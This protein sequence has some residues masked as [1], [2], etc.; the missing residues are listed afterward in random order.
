MRRFVR[1]A[2]H[3]HHDDEFS[4]YGKGLLVADRPATYESQRI[5]ELPPWVGPTA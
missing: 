2:L 4:V 1:G 3:L 5:M